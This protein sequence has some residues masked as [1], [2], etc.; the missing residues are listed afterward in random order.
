MIVRS[1]QT[2]YVGYLNVST[3]NILKHLYYE[4]ACISVDDFHNNDVS[5]KNAYDPDQPIESL[6]DQVGNALD[7]DASGNTPYSPAQ[8]DAT[9]FQL[10]FAT[11]MFLDDCKT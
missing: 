3:R 5:L 10:L 8:V 2:K 7:Y 1:L 6:F 9:A 11:G 4:Y